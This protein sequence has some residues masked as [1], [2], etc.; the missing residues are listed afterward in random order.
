MRS[1]L[2]FILATTACDHGSKPLLQVRLIVP[3]TCPVS[4]ARREWVVQCIGDSPHEVEGNPGQWVHACNAVSR[5]MFC[6]P[7]LSVHWGDWIAC[8]GLPTTHR[9]WRSCEA[10]VEESCA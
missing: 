7:V 6:E 5:D 10:A 3:A 2:L 9:G 1:I 4:D 8:E